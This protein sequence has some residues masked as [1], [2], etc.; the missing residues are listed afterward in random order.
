MRTK[1]PFRRIDFLKKLH[2]IAPPRGHLYHI[3]TTSIK[4]S[5]NDV[6]VLVVGCMSVSFYTFFIYDVITTS[7]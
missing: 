6:M 3:P 5:K 1:V 4:P 2:R 7:Y